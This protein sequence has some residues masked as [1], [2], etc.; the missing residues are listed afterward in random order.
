MAGNVERLTFPGRSM[1]DAHGAQRPHQGLCQRDIAN[2][3][4][5]V[6]Q[7]RL[8]PCINSSV[9]GSSSVSSASPMAPSRDIEQTRL[10]GMLMRVL[11]LWE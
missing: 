4:G 8:Q 1:A 10:Q 2:G 11:S 5:D 6:K 9:C 7:T 3:Q